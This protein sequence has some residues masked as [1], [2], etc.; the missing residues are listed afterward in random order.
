MLRKIGIL[1]WYIV[2]ALALWTVLVLGP[3]ALAAITAA[4]LHGAAS[5]VLGLAALAFFVVGSGIMT[6]WMLGAILDRMF[7]PDLEA[8]DLPTTGNPA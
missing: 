3:A 2:C 5:L 6:D 7:G 1:A 8:F 4:G